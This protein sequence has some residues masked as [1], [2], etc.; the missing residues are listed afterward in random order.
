MKGR[1]GVKRFCCAVLVFMVNIVPIGLAGA[2]E[3]VGLAAIGG[4]AL[5]AGV[6]DASKKGGP[7]L[8]DCGSLTSVLKKVARQGKVGGRQLEK[9]RP[10]N[11][12]EAEANLAAARRNPALRR[13]LERVAAEVQDPAVRLAYEAAVL[14]EEGFYA[15]RD[16][17]IQQLQ[18]AAK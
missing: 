14:D 8:A 7:P 4:G 9:D 18:Q 2:A 3:C 6:Q 1:S 16:L 10:L 13:R 17:K 12:A 11:V 15:A 5:G